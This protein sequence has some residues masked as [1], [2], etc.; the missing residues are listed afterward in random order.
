MILNTQGK[1]EEANTYYRRALDLSPR[2]AL[3]A[4]NLASNLADYGGNL[5]EAL[6]FAQLAREVAP[7]NPNVADTLGWILYRKGLVDSALPL[8]EEAAGGKE[9]HPAVLYHYGA[10]LAKKGK[11]EEAKKHLSEALKISENFPGAEEAKK[12]L[13]SLQ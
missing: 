9:R 3:A 13:E 1:I 5:D 8:I 2:N 11:N 6:K 7:A 10:V 12:M 4:N